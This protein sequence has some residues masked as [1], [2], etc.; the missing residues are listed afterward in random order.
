[1]TIELNEQEI[2]TLQEAL[3]A[4]LEAPTMASIIASMMTVALTGCNPD[5]MLSHSE[6]RAVAV[7][8]IRK[9]LHDQLQSKLTEILT[10]QSEFQ[11]E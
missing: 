10:R 6:K 7:T 2:K 9:P 4:Y 11:A 5:T 1:M 3:K 8:A